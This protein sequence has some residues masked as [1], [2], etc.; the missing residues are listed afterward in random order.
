MG[1]QQDGIISLF[2]L[3]FYLLVSHVLSRFLVSMISVVSFSFFI[4]C[5]LCF[6]SP[7]L[8]VTGT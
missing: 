4:I 2:F 1:G 5:F 6:W 8:G 7:Q 3:C